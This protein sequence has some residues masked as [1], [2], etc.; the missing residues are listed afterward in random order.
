MDSQCRNR[1]VRLIA[2][3][4]MGLMSVPAIPAPTADVR[5]VLSTVHALVDAWREPSVSKAKA[6]LHEEYRAESWQVSNKG[7]F[8]FLENRDH[9]LG[10]IAKLRPGEWD[11]RFLDERVNIDPNGMAAVWV[12]YVFYSHGKPHHCGFESYTLFRTLDGWK[13]VNF[14][15]TDTP[16]RGREPATVCTS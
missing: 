11:V 12:Q 5:E 13:I 10:Q 14:A 15:D 1:S 9:L 2:A 4:L 7:H 16:L 3:F 6:A 8:V